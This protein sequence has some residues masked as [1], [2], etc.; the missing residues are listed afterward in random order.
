MLQQPLKDP[1]DIKA[2]DQMKLYRRIMAA[3]VHICARHLNKPE[4]RT[5]FEKLQ[6]L[7]EA[8]SSYLNRWNIAISKYVVKTDKK[9]VHLHGFLEENSDFSDDDSLKATL[10]DT[11]SKKSSHRD[12]TKVTTPLLGSSQKNHIKYDKQA[13]LLVQLLKN[14]ENPELSS[15]NIL[16]I[17]FNDAEGSNIV[18]EEFTGQEINSRNPFCLI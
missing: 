13:S 14:K 4:S 18:V 16:N 5:K 7:L 9:F 11:E 15:D 12:S 3:N 2:V 6:S 17:S 1:K 10:N 8:G